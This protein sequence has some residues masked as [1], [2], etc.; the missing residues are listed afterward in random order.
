M[1]K[2]LVGLVLV[3]TVMVGALGVAVLNLSDRV[4]AGSRRGTVT[5]RKGVEDRSVQR[6]EIESLLKQVGILTRELE[7]VR[8]AQRKTAAALARRVARGDA[9]ANGGSDGPRDG[10]AR[11][12]G[13]GPGLT[14]PDGGPGTVVTP[15]DEA[16]YTAV[17][18][19]VDRKRRIQG[20]LTNTMRRIDRL[21][22]SGAIVALP[23]NQRADVEKVVLDYVTAADDLLTRYVRKPTDELK[24]L[25]AA[26][27]REAMN[28]DRDEIVREAEL[29][30]APLLGDA[31]TQTIVERTLRSRRTWRGSNRFGDRGRR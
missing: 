12:D 1:Q 17:K 2:M 6:E 26:Q 19:S 28:K 13:D 24:A 8:S 9:S 10:N 23:D 14:R 11:I 27:R 21:A 7:S 16:W 3:L 22:T 18:E 31:D 29:A 20:Q 15:E 25:P 4:S 5:A 30:L